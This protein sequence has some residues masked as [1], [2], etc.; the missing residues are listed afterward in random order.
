M[1]NLGWISLRKLVDFLQL[2]SG[3]RVPFQETLF[4][5]TPHYM[6]QGGSCGFF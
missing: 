5:A 1:C 6:L 4:I 3:A 2:F